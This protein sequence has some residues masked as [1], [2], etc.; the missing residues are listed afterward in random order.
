MTKI[1]AF[2]LWLP[3]WINARAFRLIVNHKS[4][5]NSS[6]LLDFKM[7]FLGVKKPRVRCLPHIRVINFSGELKKVKKI[8]FLTKLKIMMLFIS[9]KRKITVLE[10]SLKSSIMSKLDHQM[11]KI[12]KKVA[13]NFCS[14]L[15][16]SLIH[17]S[18]PTRPY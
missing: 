10:M 16:L 8:F 4:L 11:S 3:F 12:W 2:D 7:I 17:I 9:P 15:N 13:S 1:P 6:I 18:E 14:L 5:R